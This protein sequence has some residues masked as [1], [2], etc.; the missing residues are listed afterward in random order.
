MF[1]ILQ[2]VIAVRKLSVLKVVLKYN[3]I[4]VGFGWV[5]W[6]FFLFDCLCFNEGNYKVK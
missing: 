4:K 5:C 1:A 3:Q 6:G 2:V